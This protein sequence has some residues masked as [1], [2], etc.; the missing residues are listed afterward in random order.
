MLSKITATKYQVSSQNTLP[1]TLQ[2]GEKILKEV[3]P[4]KG[5]L[6]LDVAFD[7]ILP[8]LF[9]GLMTIFAIFTRAGL[10]VLFPL[11]LTIIFCIMPILFI[12]RLP[13]NYGSWVTTHRAISCDKTLKYRVWSMPFECIETVKVVRTLSDRIMGSASLKIS[14][15]G[16]F[17]IPS[18]PYSPITR[19]SGTNF[20]DAIPIDK[21]KD[22]QKVILDRVTSNSD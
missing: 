14:V 17:R 22:I 13:E 12:K 11:G 9:F 7:F 4:V 16:G 20:F 21:A 2:N 15:I 5:S 8:L 3:K 19:I 6:A 10:F 18:M 1:F